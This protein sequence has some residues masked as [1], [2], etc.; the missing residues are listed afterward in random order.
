MYLLVALLWLVGILARPALFN[1]L[2][3]FCG[4]VA[5]FYP[6]I[7]K[8]LLLHPS[9]LHVVGMFCIGVFYWI[10]RQAVPINAW[11][12]L[13]MLFGAGALH[14]TPK[15]G[16]AYAMVLPYLLWCLA[17]APG[18]LWFNRLGDYSYGVY[19]YG[20]PVQQC[21]ASSFPSMTVLQN[22]FSAIAASLVLAIASWHLIERPSLSLKRWFRN[23]SA[24]GATP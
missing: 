10:N 14:G 21:L 8:P 22:T 1:F 17:F 20:W 24:T 4:L 5:Y 9:H 18:L 6:T 12:L 16:F 15:F 19:L 23:S 11:F 2:F 7:Y 3:F 13:L